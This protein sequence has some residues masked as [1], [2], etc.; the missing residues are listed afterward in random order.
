LTPKVK[1]LDIVRYRWS[2]YFGVYNG[3]HQHRKLSNAEKEKYFF[4]E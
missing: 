4:P 3:N 1:F 2:Q